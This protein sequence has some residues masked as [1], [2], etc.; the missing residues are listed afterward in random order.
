M[1]HIVPQRQFWCNCCVV[2]GT[3]NSKGS[4]R[5]LQACLLS[6]EQEQ[7]NR[8]TRSNG[9]QRLSE[10][11]SARTEGHTLPSHYHLVF[12]LCSSSH[13]TSQDH[14]NALLAVFIFITVFASKPKSRKLKFSGIS[15]CEK[16]FSVLKVHSKHFNSHKIRAFVPTAKT[17]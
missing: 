13:M 10:L 3:H 4:S 2:V 14:C 15:D 16:N 5:R 11:Q 7:V 12:P 1:C 6:T 17:Q 9:P 8:K